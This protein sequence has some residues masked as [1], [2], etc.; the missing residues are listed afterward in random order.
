MRLEVHEHSYISGPNAHISGRGLVHSHAG[1]DKPHDHEHT[2][3]STYTI[4]KDEWFR[5]TGL[6]GGGRKKFTSKPSGEQLPMRTVLAPTF[7][8]IIHDSAVPAGASGP[9]LAPI[10]RLE[11]AFGA[12]VGRVV[13]VVRG[14]KAGAR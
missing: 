4:D 13:H 2:G 1:G 10:A 5:A 8:V 6:K 12:R 11:Q 7:D 9:G 14:R 3:P